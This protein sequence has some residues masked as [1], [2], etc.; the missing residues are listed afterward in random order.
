[1]ESRKHEGFLNLLLDTV[2]DARL[3]AA[4][5]FQSQIAMFLRQL[6]ESVETVARVPIVLQVGEAL[7][8]YVIGLAAH[9]REHARSLQAPEAIA[10]LLWRDLES[11][12]KRSPQTRYTPEA[13]LT[14]DLREPARA[15]LKQA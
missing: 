15:L 1:M 2:L 12:L 6:V 5:L 7:P 13:C 11:S 4:N 8:G 3:A 14:C 10:I 9:G